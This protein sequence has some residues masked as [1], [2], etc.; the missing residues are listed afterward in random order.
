MD[1]ALCIQKQGEFV[2]LR[3]ISMPTSLLSAADLSTEQIQFLL[4]IA[5][6]FLSQKTLTIPLLKGK[7]IVN[8]F[9]ENSTRTR[10]SFELAIRRLEGSTLNFAASTS[11]TQKG[12]TLIDTAR[13]ITAMGPHAIIMRH[14]SSGSPAVLARTIPIPIINAGD[15]FHEHP[16]QALLDAFTIRQKLG[17]IE[18]KKIVIIGDIAHS[19]VARSN[20]SILKNSEPALPSVVLRPSFRRILKHW[21]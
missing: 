7:T 1:L 20:I 11:S 16:T 18:G 10:T 13:N 15:G 5:T 2:N 8:L 21:A 6:L 12:E 14:A 3:P 4:E 17:S 9:F 19:R